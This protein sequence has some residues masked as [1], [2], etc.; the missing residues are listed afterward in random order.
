MKKNIALITGGTT[1]EA[2]ISLKSAST[3]E[4]NLDNDLFDVYKIVISSKNWYALEKNNEQISV[5][6]NDFSIKI[7][8]KKITF[9]CAFIMIHG[10][11]GEDGKLQGYLDML[12]I[13]YT[14][15]GTTTAALTMN[16]SY[17]KNVITHIK[18]LKTASSVLLFKK[19]KYQLEE[20]ASNLHFPLFIKPNNGGSSIGM[21]KVLSIEKL[22]E[23]LKKAFKE[24]NQV[25]IEEFVKGREFTVGVME[26]KNKIEVLP[27]TEIISSRD[28]FDYEA[29]Y[30]QGL[31]N[32]ITP[33]PLSESEVAMIKKIVTQIY[34]HLDCKGVVRIDFILDQN[35]GEFYFI[36]INTIPG[37][38]V[39][40]IIPQ[41]VRA[42]GL[43]LNEFY[44]QLITNCLNA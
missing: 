17:T 23:A 6:K 4:K 18:G 16:K 41:Q 19:Q 12:D 15:C 38:T 33:A 39:A 28:F 34:Q 1:K 2:E 20:V 27:I 9:D 3:V 13:P 42:F 30:T 37:Q 44:S 36:E 29:K 10:S 22:D 8:H 7:D 43:S 14:S 31:A 24:G 35:H 5:D 26:W 25:L 21:S 40:S 32:E 11:P